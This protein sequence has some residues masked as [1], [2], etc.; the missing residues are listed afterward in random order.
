MVQPRLDHAEEL[1]DT[2]VAAPETLLGQDDTGEAGDQGAVQVE[3]G[4]DFR[5]GP[6]GNHLGNR[7]GQPQIP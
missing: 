2:H 1:T 5:P 6:A 3:E 7:T 4:A